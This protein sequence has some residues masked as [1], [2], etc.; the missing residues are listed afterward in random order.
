VL[1]NEIAVTRASFPGY[2]AKSETTADAI[3]KIHMEKQQNRW[4]GCMNSKRY[5]TKVRVYFVTTLGTYILAIY[6]GN[7]RI[8]GHTAVTMHAKRAYGVVKVLPHSL[9]TSAVYKSECQ[10][11]DPAT[12]LP[13]KTVPGTRLRDSRAGLDDSE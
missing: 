5:T 3:K 12:L 9:L 8:R 10:V 13:Q 1:K 2:P 6:F 7:F 4:T 11:H